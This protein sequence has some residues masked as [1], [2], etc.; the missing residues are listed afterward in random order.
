MAAQ[1]QSRIQRSK[2]SYVWKIIKNF[3]EFK[4]YKTL[5]KGNVKNGIGRD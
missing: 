1:L 3:K 4:Y 5:E 2:L